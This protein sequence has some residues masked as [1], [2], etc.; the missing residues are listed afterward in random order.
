MAFCSAAIIPIPALRCFALQ[1]AILIA[2]ISIAVIILFPALASI[3]L[4]FRSMYLAE[5][6]RTSSQSSL[7]TS[8]FVNMCFYLF[9]CRT[10]HFRKVSSSTKTTKANKT[11]AEKSSSVPVSSQ[12]GLFF[13]QPYLYKQPYN[14]V[15]LNSIQTTTDE[16]HSFNAKKLSSDVNTT[17]N[18]NI[19]RCELKTNP[20]KSA[21]SDEQ[22][23]MMCAL[24]TRS[25]QK[26]GG[27]LR[28][29]CDGQDDDESIAEEFSETLP[30]SPSTTSLSSTNQPQQQQQL[31]LCSP[32]V[33]PKHFQLKFSTAQFATDYLGPFLKRRPAKVLISLIYVVIMV[34]S[35]M[36]ITKVNDGLD[37]TD[38]VPRSTNEYQFLE[39][40]KQYFT[41]YNMFVVT[42]GNFDYPNNQRILYE[43]HQSFNRIDAIIKNDDGGLPE[44]WLPI[45]RDWLKELQ[46]AFDHDRERGCITRERWYS[47]ASNEAILA[48]KLLVQTGRIDNPVDKSL[49]LTARLVDQ[50]GIINPKA[51]YNYLTA[52]ASND[53]M[54]YDSTQ[55]SFK[56]EPRQWI[57]EANDVELK[58]PKS[59]PLI[60]TQ[61]PFHLNNI[62]TTDEII[63]TIQDV[64]AVCSRFENLGLPNFP[65]GIPFT[66][67]EQYIRLRFYMMMALLAVLAG[68]FFS[69]SVLLCSLWTPMIIVFNLILNIVQ[70]F[71]FMG[72]IGIK[73][74]ALPAVI[75]I[76]SVG[77]SLNSL[78]HITIVSFSLLLIL[79]L[80][81]I[82]HFFRA[83][84]RPS[85]LEIN[86]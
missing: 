84:I 86:E 58:I 37:L 10:P 19:C 17:E 62:R 81:V 82:I 34:F 44:F 21:S 43:Y 26:C 4:R 72:W 79:Q 50:Q 15:Y 77:I 14:F 83:L 52:W 7:S 69:T 70:L 38:L 1:T 22:S 56:P 61:I 76:V 51:F 78:I 29:Q 35:I 39:L 47:N 64:R 71:G 24:M 25:C 75:L 12:P 59:P 57:H 27:E 28:T 5:T 73:L 33:P 45:F 9:C 68:I 65:T 2:I 36:G 13:K 40:R 48:Y 49:V 85:V 80:N 16:N 3:D 18:D 30:I 60:F 54:A 8:F 31:S 11:L 66:Y 55:A 53:M 67:W 32:A 42:K 20:G 41:Y 6:G 63:K 23:M 74:S 46:D